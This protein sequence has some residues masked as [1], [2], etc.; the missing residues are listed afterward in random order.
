MKVTS[1]KR[2]IKAREYSSRWAKSHRKKVSVW[3]KRWRDANPEKCHGYQRKYY[4]KNKEKIRKRC[5]EWDKENPGKHH[6]YQRQ[7]R[8]KKLGKTLA[9][10]DQMFEQQNGV[11][12]ICGQ[13][14]TQI[15]KRKGKI[16][17]LSVDH[18]HKTGQ[19][20]K[21]LCYKCNMLLGYANEDIKILSCVIEYLREY[22]K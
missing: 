1:E 18:N 11:C 20:R 9:D 21:L 7:S 17:D 5:K 10:Y 14:E 12:A 8:L 3:N 22:D 19:V 2:K 16:K 15:D 4:E 13:P 6:L